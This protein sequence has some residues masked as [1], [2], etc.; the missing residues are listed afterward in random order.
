MIGK[1]WN[2]SARL[3]TELAI[4]LIKAIPSLLRGV[5]Q[6]KESIIKNLYNLVSNM[7]NIGT[8]LVKGIWTGI[9]N[10][11]GWLKSKISGWIGN[12]TNFIRKMFKIGSPSKLW[13][14]QIGKWLPRGVAVGIDANTDSIE[15]SINDMYK[16]M[17]RT[18][19][20][21]NSKMN[22]DVVSGDVYNKSFF[23]TPV[24]INVNADV[25]MDS[26]KVGRLVTPSVT[27][28]IKNGGGI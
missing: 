12:V 23:Q 19:K 15:D 28:T 25:E 7:G 9:I 1:I 5:S 14:D 27:R 13:A 8:N 21:E 20:M 22:F 6:I 17:N 2:A 16:E 3:V 24:A 10:S 4:G 26:Q 11:S 18:I